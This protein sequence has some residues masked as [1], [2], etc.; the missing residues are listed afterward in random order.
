MPPSGPNWIAAAK[1]FAQDRCVPGAAPGTI[2]K[3]RATV[4]F[5]KERHGPSAVFFS[6]EHIE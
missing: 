6:I 1:N 4:R 5:V 3:A 2:E